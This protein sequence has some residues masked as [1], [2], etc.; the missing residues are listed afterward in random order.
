MAD[1]EFIPVGKIAG[2]FGVKGWMKIFSL[3]QPRTN[4]LKYSPLFIS[5]NGEWVEAKVSGGHSQGKGIVMGLEQVTDRD[6][7][8][9][10]IGAELAIRKSQ[11]PPAKEGEF[12][13]SDLIGLSVINLEQQNLGVV[14][15]LLETGAHDV[16]VVKDEQNTERLIPFVMEEIVSDVDLDAKT[17]H[18]DWGLDY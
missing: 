12:Y 15:H 6:Q 1:E 9:P 4:I 14:D 2:A 18:V 17:I 5:R 8:M 7:V 10:L 16:L 13:W 11:L 3:T